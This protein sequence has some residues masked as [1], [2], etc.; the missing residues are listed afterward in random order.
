MPGLVK[1]GMSVK[2]PNLRVIELS[3]TGV[4]TPFV[5]EYYAFFYDMAQAEKIA[6]QT[7]NKYHHGKEFFSIDVA[8]AI[9]AIENTGLPFRRLFSKPEDEQKIEEIRIEEKEKI[10]REEVKRKKKKGKEKRIARARRL[11]ELD[12]ERIRREERRA[13][14]D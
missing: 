11:L 6:H 14:K 7:L 12:I 4:P 13:K 8:A 2:T 9:N 5:L 1:V 3:S 10:E